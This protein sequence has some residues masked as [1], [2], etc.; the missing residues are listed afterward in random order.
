MFDLFGIN[1]KRKLA[2]LEREVADLR[3]CRV[4]H[5]GQV[6]GLSMQVKQLRTIAEQMRARVR[7]H[8]K[9][10]SEAAF[11]AACM[12]IHSNGKMISTLRFR[13][14]LE[15]INRDRA[16][17]NDSPEWGAAQRVTVEDAQRPF[18]VF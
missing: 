1:A 12:D 11:I 5:E 16:A 8:G 10:S 13:S 4:I 6:S 18:E 3:E 14:M 15:L 17:L 7:S 9:T 2:E